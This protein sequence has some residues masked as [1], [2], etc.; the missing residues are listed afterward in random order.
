[1]GRGGHK[2]TYH[3]KTTPT[4]TST[5]CFHNKTKDINWHNLFQYKRECSCACWIGTD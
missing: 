5:F 4:T 2:V 1:M 3:K